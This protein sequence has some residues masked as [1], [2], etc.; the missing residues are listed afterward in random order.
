VEAACRHQVLGYRCSDVFLR[1]KHLAALEVLAEEGFLY[2]SSLTPAALAFRKEPWRRF[3]HQQLF[4]ASSIWEFPIS[5]HRIGSLMIPFAGGNYFRQYPE[6]FVRWAITEW[7][8]VQP[9]PLVLYFRVWDLDPHHP[10]IHTGSLVRDLRHYRNSSRMVRILGELLGTYRFNSIAGT[11][12]QSQQPEPVRPAPATNTVLTIRPVKSVPMRVSVSVI[13]PCHNEEASIPYLA[14]SLDELKVELN[15]AYELQFI[16]VDD[17]SSDNTWLLLDQHF[18][19][20]ADV[21]LVRHDRN[22]GV[23]AAI[24][25]GLEHAHEV[26][27]SMDCDC[28]YDPHQLKPMLG[29]LAEDV[30]L[31]VASPYHPNGRVLNVPSWRIALSKGASILYQIVTG[32]RLHTFTSCLRVYRRSVALATP[33]RYSGFL[34]IAELTGRFVLDGRRVVEHPAT[35]ELRLFGRSK[36]RI[37]STIAGHIQLLVSLGWSRLTEV[38]GPGSL[39][40]AAKPSPILHVQPGDE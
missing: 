18:G 21:L 25:T 1:P 14:R 30:D 13:V 20:R 24:V 6:T 33:L 28:S 36:M 3:V 19:S 5:S 7:D 17:G 15:D 34:G 2:D 12:Q 9:H 23:A 27:C 11:L 16:L 10:R 38:R 8:R 40:T 32:R 26:A 31:V 22:R 39:A 4:A 37:L 29:L 35:L